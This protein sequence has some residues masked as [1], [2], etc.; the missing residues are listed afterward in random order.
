M[1]LTISDFQKIA[2]GSHNAGDITLTSSGNPYIASVGF[3][4]S[5]EAENMQ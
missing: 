4:Q 1:N 5:I 3:G 2:N